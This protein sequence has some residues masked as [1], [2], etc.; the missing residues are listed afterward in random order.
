[1]QMLINKRLFNT[2]MGTK[3]T[4]I[5]PAPHWRLLQHYGGH[6]NIVQFRESFNKMA[7][8]CGRYSFPYRLVPKALFQ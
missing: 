8:N 7:E 4:V 2:I 5:N 1:M 3:T 6:L